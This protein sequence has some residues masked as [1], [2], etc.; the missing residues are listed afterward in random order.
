VTVEAAWPH[1]VG[2]LTGLDNQYGAQGAVAAQLIVLLGLVWYEQKLSATGEPSG[3]L[4]VLETQVTV[5]V[6]VL[7]SRPQSVGQYALLTF[8]SYD[9]HSFVAGQCMVD[10]GFG[11]EQ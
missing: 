1:A 6:T 11:S 5:R 3:W 4:Y 2:Q 9:A 10:A 8:H 7:A